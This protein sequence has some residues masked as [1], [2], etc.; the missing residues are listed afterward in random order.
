M[1]NN[2]F[3]F[4]SAPAFTVSSGA[5][6]LL[7]AAGCGGSTEIK[8]Y[9][10]AKEDSHAQVAHAQ[11]SA[12]GATTERPAIPHIHGEAAQGWQEM[13]PEKM[14]VASYRITGE[15]GK[16]AELAVIPLPGVGK[17]ELRSVNMWREE[18]GLAELTSEQL[19]EQSQSV[20]VGDTQG[21]MVH[22]T[23]SRGGESNGASTGILGA[24]AERG[25]VTWFIKMMGDQDVVAKQKN[26]FVA[27]LKS[28]EFHEGSHGAG[29]TAQANTAE[30]EKPTQLAQA[31]SAEKPVSTNTEKS[32]EADKPNFKAPETW[33]SKTPGQM[34]LS[35]YN[36]EGDGGQ[37]EVTISKFPG[38]VGGMVANIQRWRGQLG[39]APGSAEEAQKSAEMVEIGG[40][41]E[42]YLVDLKGTNARTGKPAR[43]VAM[44]VP[45]QGE[46]WFF[47]L[48]GDEAVV[49]KEKD[50]FVRFIKS[51]Y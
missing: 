5:A 15:G 40:K 36:I 49:G 25:N 8:T 17:I 27:Y 21:L 13:Q 22:L 23:G 37:A 12:A 2:C 10:V 51:A 46:T 16:F 34:I 48:M 4:F 33:K 35:A 44:G 9:R 38:A 26:N 7:F 39:L 3:R 18:L 11:A 20:P 1:K 29:S 42:A 24:V 14:R 50:A 28:L 6:A 47:K 31:L 19:K 32:P 41:K 45:Y 43:M 30:S